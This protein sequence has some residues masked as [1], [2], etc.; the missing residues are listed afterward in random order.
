MGE[1]GASKPRA[2]APLTACLRAWDCGYSPEVLGFASVSTKKTQWLRRKM[3][4]LDFQSPRFSWSESRHAGSRRGSKKLSQ[5][6]SS[7]TAQCSWA[8]VRCLLTIVLFLNAGKQTRTHGRA[9]RGLSAR[10]C[11]GGDGPG[12]WL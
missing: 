11:L 4:R 7:S 9:L 12:V 1:D 3:R 2:V 8:V 5:A 10:L 6:V